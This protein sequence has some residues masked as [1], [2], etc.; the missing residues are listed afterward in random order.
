MAKYILCDCKCKLN[1]K[2]VIMKHVN[3]SVKFIVHEKM[4]IAGVLFNKYS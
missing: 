3:V 1:S 4:I 2:N